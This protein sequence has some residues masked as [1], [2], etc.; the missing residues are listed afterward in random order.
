[1]YPGQVQQAVVKWLG[2]Y[3]VGGGLETFLNRD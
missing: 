1:M 2:H 3:F